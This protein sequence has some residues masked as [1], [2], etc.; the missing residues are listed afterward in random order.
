MA[1]RRTREKCYQ[2]K[3][4]ERLLSESNLSRSVSFQLV[5]WQ[6]YQCILFSHSSLRLIWANS[7]QL[8]ADA[9]RAW[10]LAHVGASTLSVSLPLSMRM[11]S[12][13]SQ[14]IHMCLS[15]VFDRLRG[16]KLVDGASAVFVTCVLIRAWVSTDWLGLRLSGFLKSFSTT[17]K[18]TQKRILHARILAL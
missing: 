12:C 7:A 5:I 17:R 6:I 4:N 10:C 1:E 8:I 11:G 18:R 2:K 15:I 9:P 13:V 14:H 3:K 16:L